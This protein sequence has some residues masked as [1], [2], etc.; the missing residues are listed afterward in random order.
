MYV[1]TRT[2]QFYSTQRKKISKPSL[3]GFASASPY[4]VIPTGA[5]RFFLGSVFERGLRSAGT[6]LDSSQS[7]DE[8]SPA[9][10]FSAAF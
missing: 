6:R 7:A 10:R 2:I 9:F 8:N 1:I 5:A 3:K 4:F